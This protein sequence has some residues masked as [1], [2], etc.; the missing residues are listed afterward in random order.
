MDTQSWRGPLRRSKEDFM[1]EN[2]PSQQPSTAP[3]QQ[4]MHGQPQ[5][6]GPGPI[7]SMPDDLSYDMIPSDEVAPERRRRQ[8]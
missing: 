8:G 7:E 6:G 2:N 5:P 4:P 1:P 3:N